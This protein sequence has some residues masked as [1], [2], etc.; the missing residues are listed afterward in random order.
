MSNAFLHGYLKEEVYMQQPPSYVDAT[1]P[2]YVCKLPK[3]LYGLKQAP[4]AWFERFTF[5]LIHFGFQA[6]FADS[7]LFIFQ[8]KSTIIYLLLYVDDIIITGNN[9]Q[10]VSSLI[11]IHSSVFELKDLGDLNYFLGVQISR[12]QFGLTLC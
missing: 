4:Q 6:S 2:S 7:S 8:S 9:S 1:N 11:A 5:H 12:T 10:H 3:S